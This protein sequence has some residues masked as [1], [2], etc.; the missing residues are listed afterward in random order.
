M[1]TRIDKKLIPLIHRAMQ[2]GS[3]S[4]EESVKYANKLIEVV[5]RQIKKYGSNSVEASNAYGHI[6]MVKKI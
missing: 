5:E 4:A 6:E 3:V 1:K 2:T